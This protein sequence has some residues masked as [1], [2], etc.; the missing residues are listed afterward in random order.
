LQYQQSAVQP[1]PAPNRYYSDTGAEVAEYVRQARIAQGLP[2]V[3]EDVTGLDFYAAIVARA[4]TGSQV[5]GASS[6]NIGSAQPVEG[7][8]VLF[9]TRDTSPIDPNY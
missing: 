1:V 7:V 6:Y 5:G 3:I 2:P 9:L 4:G 8:R